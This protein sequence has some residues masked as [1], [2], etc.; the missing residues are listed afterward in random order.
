MEKHLVGMAAAMAITP[1]N[2]DITRFLLAKLKEDTA[3]DA[4][5]QSLQED[6]L[7][8]IPESVSEM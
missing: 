4:M 5:D 3:P 1:T 2:D 8:D 7:N 6:I